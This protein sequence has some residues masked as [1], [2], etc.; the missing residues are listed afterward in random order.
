[1]QE[2]PKTAMSKSGE[3]ECVA[4]S[5][6]IEGIVFRKPHFVER[7]VLAKRKG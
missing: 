4:Y 1:M 7:G 3:S 6:R 5:H 2:E